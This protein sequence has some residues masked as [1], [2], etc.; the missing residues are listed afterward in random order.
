MVS[1]WPSVSSV[2]QLSLLSIIIWLMDVLYCFATSA[3]LVFAVT[4]MVAV[5]QPA[6]GGGG[7]G[8]AVVESAETAWYGA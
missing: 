1:C 2:F 5:W 8:G 3:R 4:L 6:T 7:G